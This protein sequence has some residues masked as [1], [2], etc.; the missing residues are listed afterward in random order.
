MFDLASDDAASE[1]TLYYLNRA[2]ESNHIDL[3]T[4]L[5]VSYPLSIHPST[6]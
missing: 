4:F 2:L 5:K 6:R 1:D 3:E